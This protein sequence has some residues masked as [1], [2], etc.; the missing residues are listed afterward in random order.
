MGDLLDAVLA[1]LVG[2][3][4]PSSEK[5]DPQP[6]ECTPLGQETAAILSDD[7]IEISKAT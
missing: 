3:D 4:K 6:V 2:G 7:E 5:P 1:T